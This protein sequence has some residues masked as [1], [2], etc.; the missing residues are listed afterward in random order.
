MSANARQGGCHG[1][2]TKS[3]ATW[4]LPHQNLDDSQHLN[5]NEHRSRPETESVA[6]AP[7]SRPAEHRISESTT[8]AR[9]PNVRF[10][11]EVDEG[12]STAASEDG[13]VVAPNGNAVRPSHEN[14]EGTDRMISVSRTTLTSQA[15]ANKS[16]PHHTQSKPQTR[17]R[18][19]SLR[20][21]LFAKK[22][23]NQTEQDAV[24]IE[25]E[26]AGPSEGHSRPLSDNLQN[27]KA[28]KEKPVVKVSTLSLEA[29]QNLPPGLVK[30]DDLVARRPYMKDRSLDRQ[31][32]FKPLDVARRLYWNVKTRLLRLNKIAPSSDGRHIDLDFSSPIA[33]IDERTGR[34]YIG[35]TI[36]SSRYTL[37]NF[38][39]RQFVAQFSKLAN[40]YF[41][42]VAILQMIPGLSTTGTYTTIIPLMFFV[43][44]S[45]GKEGYDDIRRYR[46]DKEENNRQASVLDKQ[47]RGQA[48]VLPDD[49]TC[50]AESSSAIWK[51]EKWRNIRVGDIL[52]IDRDQ[53]IPADILLLHSVD[54]KGG[55]FIETMALDGET[56]LK[57]KQPLP[58]LAK[59]CKTTDAIARSRVHFVV[60]DPN[61]DLYKFE[62]KTTVGEEVL[63]LTN[64]EV[65]YRGS[66]LR[67][68]E[69]IYGFVIYTGEECKIRMNANK[70]PRIKAP[71]LQAA[72]N[73]VVVII[74]TFVVLLA[75]FCT[76]AY[77][78][79]AK[80][81]E[82]KSWYLHHAKVSFG[83]VFVSYAIM[84]NTFLPLSLYVS[85]EIVKVFQMFLMNDI[86]M[87]DETS[88]TPLEARTSTINEE[89]GQISYIFSD[90]T[91]TL[92]NNCMRFRK[93]S[94]AGTAWLHDRDLREEVREEASKER[95]IHK[96]RTTKGKMLSSRKSSVSQTVHAVRRSFGFGVNGTGPVTAE[97]GRASSV[98]APLQTTLLQ[99]RNT[100]GGRTEEMLES[101][102]RGSH[103]LFSRKARFF[104]LALALC[105]TCIPEK[106]E[107]GE[108]SFQAASP[109][110]LALVTAAQDF[111][112]TV[113]DRQ[114][115]SITVKTSPSENEDEPVYDVYEILDVIEFSSGRKRMSIIVRMPDQRICIFC[116]GADSIVTNLLRLKQLAS[117]QISEVEHRASQRKSLEAQEA[118]RRRSE[119]QGSA[120]GRASMSAGRGSITS[121]GRSS[122]TLGRKQSVRESVDHWLKE[123]ET[124]VDMM[125]KRDNTPF[126]SPRPSAHGNTPR[127]SAQGPK[128]TALATQHSARHS[129][130]NED[131]ASLVDEALVLNDS[132]VFQRCF[133]HINDFAT[134]GLRTLL[135]G[136]R[137][138]GEDEYREWKKQYQEATTSLADRQYLVEQAGERIEKS[139]EL[140]G[141]TAIEDKLQKDV[142]DTIDR[143]RRAGIKLWMLTGD[144]RE[145]AINI[146]HSCRLIK[147]YSNVFVLDHETGGMDRHMAAAIVKIQ[148]GQVAHSVIVIDGHTL[149]LIDAQEGVKKLFLDVAVLADSVICCRA[150][151]SQKASLVKAIRTKVRGSV[152]L[153]IGDGAND[154]AMIQE[155]HV[156]IGIAG[157]EGLQAARTSDWSI[158]QFRFLT[159]LLL[160]HGRWNYIRICKYTLGTFWKVR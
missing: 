128:R 71:T 86:D 70:N 134:E 9:R 60:E 107:E 90:K 127:I 34:S 8:M 75:F 42:C 91:G 38:F 29:D 54:T 28:A 1:I 150:S 95:L 44:I 108:V 78:I 24:V 83:Q 132:L 120:T 26:P 36:R 81:I 160:V 115:R 97:I 130:Q 64:N 67:N 84:F 2:T 61:I 46:L 66:I 152:T 102:Q 12:P 129:L 39:P 14:V 126:H 94:V 74:A 113:V 16:S 20:R 62:G 51:R 100:Q 88:N 45:M 53:S 82:R 141:A 7:A 40:F 47:P 111:G 93:M 79:W 19:Y 5:H 119:Q 69:A 22:T 80:V 142:P 72:V 135:Y 99:V 6:A 92:T 146:G 77:H 123:R 154:I 4:P 58:A 59:V 148:S 112:Y 145:T 122:I 30:T 155:A 50:S 125:Q 103:T 104:I 87:Y 110:E 149:A 137:Y 55:A 15:P 153:A 158:A 31:L 23:N 43:G 33:Q 21:S 147:D 63:P 157:K 73:K 105:H 65:V 139:L 68:T 124:D 32:D 41:L 109:D 117:V 76:A 114:S 131:E 37:L 136:S 57:I 144:K 52:R 89:L 121:P 140:L 11:T 56:N 159:K 133:Q 85:L 48:S 116:K 10:L 25:M 49:G 101:I 18:G 106:D 13:G 151:P 3:S 17:D 156:G 138:I 118:L 27:E 96:K 143:L 35:N 98:G